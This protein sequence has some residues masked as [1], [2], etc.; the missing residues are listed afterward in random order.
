MLDGPA[1]RRIRGV[2]G[3][4]FTRA[5]VERLRLRIAAEID[6]LLNVVGRG[7]ST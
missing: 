1:H 2:I 6:R 7:R 3:K 5:S 4:V